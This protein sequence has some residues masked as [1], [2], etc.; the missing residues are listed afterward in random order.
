MRRALAFFVATGL[1]AVGAM[2]AC[3]ETLV[4]TNDPAD[5]STAGDGTTPEGGGTADADAGS[6][7]DATIDVGE[8]DLEIRPACPRPAAGT[9]CTGFKLGANECQ[10]ETLFDPPVAEH[11][12]GVVADRRHVY[13]LSQP[14]IPDAGGVAYNGNGAAI[15][16]RV[17]RS[18]REV[19][20]LARGLSKATVLYAHGP[21][22]FWAVEVPGGSWTVQTLRKTDP[23][24][25]AS[26]CP[27]PTSIANGLARVMSIG[28]LSTGF[29]FVLTGNGVLSRVDVATP[30]TQFID[31]TTDYPALAVGSGEVYLAGGTQSTVERYGANGSPL[32]ILGVMP[33][34][35][36]GNGL[37]LLTTCSKVYARGE[38]NV[39]LVIDAGAEGGAFIRHS[40][41]PDGFP[42]YAAASDERFL[43]FGA[44]NFFGLR[45]I[46][47]TVPDAAP[48]EIAE[49]SV[50]GLAVTDDAIIYGTHGGTGSN[51][52]SDIGAIISISK[53]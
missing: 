7:T 17:D 50:W 47:T 2:V 10:S 19:A 46:D 31:D 43:Y 28:A 35:S 41:L 48:I 14:L 30:S 44:A 15:L 37:Y 20:E 21:D 49:G 29:V 51:A 16:R 42:V 9:P 34:A 52:S 23:A 12:F 5:A 32:P 18:T 45:R 11:V 39:V 53:K 13:W 26:Q 8:F 33:D 24:C 22:L 27:T 38:D 25:S 36:L 3:G 4:A 6:V 1:A 40:A